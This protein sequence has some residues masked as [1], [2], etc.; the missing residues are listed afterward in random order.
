MYTETRLLPREHITDQLVR[1]VRTYPLTVLT[2]PMGYGKTTAARELVHHLGMRSFFIT[3]SPGD[4]SASYLWAHCCAQLAAQ[5]ALTAAMMGR[6]GLPQ[7]PVQVQRTVEQVRKIGATAPV[8]IV[9]DDYHVV[10][11]VAI[12]EILETLVREALPGV[13]FL[14]LSRT[15]PNLPLEELR[16]KGLAVIFTRD[17]LVF[18]GEDAASFF[19]LHGITDETAL[20]QAFRFSEGWAAALWLSLQSLRTGGVVSPVHDVEQ[21]LSAAVFSRYSREDQELLLH[22]S[23]V[24]SFSPMQAARVSGDPHAPLRLRR[25]LEQNALMSYDA[26]TDSYRLHSIFRGFLSRLLAEGEHPAA[27]GIDKAALSR[28][29]GEWFAETGDFYQ[30][31]RFLFNAGTE[32]D[33]LRVLEL[34][35]MPMDGLQ[36]MLDPTGV[37]AMIQAIPWSVRK[38]RPI[39]YLAYIYYYASRV[40][41]EEGIALLR[42]AERQFMDDPALSEGER[43]RIKGEIELIYGIED[44]NDL[45][46]MRDRHEKAY[47]LL[48]GRSRISHN[49]LIWTFGSPH[50]AF[51]YLQEPGS[52]ADLVDLVDQNLFYYQ[53]MTQGCSS[54]AQDLFRA[55][56]LLEKGELKKVE[57]Y[58]EKAAYRAAENNQLASLIAINFTWARLLLALGR[59]KNALEKVRALVARVDDSGSPLL[60][61]SMD[62]CR[63]YIA[64]VL[65]RSD[66]IP[67]WLRQG[68]IASFPAFYQG[69]GFAR[70]VHGKALL[71]GGD[72]PCLDAFAQ[73]TPARL[74]TYRNLFGYIHAHAMQAMAALHM[75]E[76]ARAVAEF[77]H[78]LRLAAPDGIVLSLAEYGIALVPLLDSLPDTTKDSPY[79]RDL[80][81]LCKRYAR[82]ASTT[83]WGL[84]PRELQILERAISGENNAAIAEA[85]G[86]KLI[87]VSKTLSRAYAKMGAANR[88]EAAKLWQA[89]RQ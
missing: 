29:T 69:L 63:G 15:R 54:G 44:Y 2:A 65:G 4:H 88:L 32:A 89:E 11:T 37:S 59:P 12:D 75:G 48:G 66:D 62:L 5:G 27:A 82:L 8:L 21:L 35:E 64:T 42:E 43:R 10:D 1:A 13:H 30:A 60:A 79:V 49:Q 52:Y 56:L 20:E 50:A 18:S 31:G 85:L 9:I 72:W 78:A 23:A 83:P 22:L 67:A 26:L 74:G 24:E 7:D 34:M 19:A 28:K 33:Y 47:G 77:D 14:L 84:A 71:M 80:T 36:V 86:L 57:P 70:I 87:T 17:L 45:Y 6:M 68:G 53:K 55:E 39:G 3:L 81:A 25:L 76:H 38:K 41:I 73:D 61:N 58:L 51:L 16:V 46:A 40:D